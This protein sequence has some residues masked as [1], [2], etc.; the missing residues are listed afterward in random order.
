MKLHDYIEK[1]AA[2]AGSVAELARVLGLTREQV[3]AAKSEKRQLPTHCAIKLANYLDA[4][5]IAVISANELATEKRPEIQEFWRGLLTP[6][7]GD[8]S[9]IRHMMN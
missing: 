8:L 1:G 6:K 9:Y 5:R 3:S 7:T 4:D 2:K